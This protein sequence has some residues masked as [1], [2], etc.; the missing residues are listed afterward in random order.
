MPELRKQDVMCPHCQRP[1]ALVADIAPVEHEPGLLA[2]M[3]DEC[4]AV[5]SRLI[6]PQR[7]RPVQVR[8]QEAA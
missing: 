7:A 6:Y 8:R 3:C 4:G 1:M 5:H 2:F